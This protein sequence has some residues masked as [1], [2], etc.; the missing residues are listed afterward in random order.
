MYSNPLALIYLKREPGNDDPV[1][2]GLRYTPKFDSTHAASLERR[3]AIASPLSGSRANRTVSM[4]R[5]A[6]SSGDPF[7]ASVI[8]RAVRVS[9]PGG[10]SKRGSA[11]SR[12]QKRNVMAQ[13]A[14]SVRR[15]KGPRMRNILLNQPAPAISA[16]SSTDGDNCEKPTAIMRALSARYC[17]TNAIRSIA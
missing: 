14:S 15:I 9:R 10:A 5:A 8:V 13:D 11:T 12:R 16:A 17:T 3:H 7:A 2:V 4:H 6:I 1:A